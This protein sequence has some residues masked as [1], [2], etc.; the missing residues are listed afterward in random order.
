MTSPK[1]KETRGGM[2]ALTPESPFLR[3]KRE[4]LNRPLEPAQKLPVHSRFCPAITIFG[5]FTASAEALCHPAAGGAA[6]GGYRRHQTVSSSR[7]FWKPSRSRIRREARPIIKS[8]SAV[9]CA[10]SGWARAQQQMASTAS[11]M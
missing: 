6:F 10:T 1:G 4:P 11:V 7:Y 3:Q 8:V 5:I 9:M 2:M